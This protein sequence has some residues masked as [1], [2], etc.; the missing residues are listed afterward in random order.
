[1]EE[2]LYVLKLRLLFYLVLKKKPLLKQETG[3]T[4]RTGKDRKK[5]PPPQMKQLWMENPET[6]VLDLSK[7]LLLFFSQT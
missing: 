1:M 6:R 4:P 2:N 3:E 5:F 7:I